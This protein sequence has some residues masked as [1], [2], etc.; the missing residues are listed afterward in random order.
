MGY[1]PERTLGN[2]P[3]WR[4]A[5]VDR[6]ARMVETF[7]NHASVIIWSLGNEAGDGVN[8]EAASA[9]V[10]RHE[11]TRPVHYERADRRTH[12]DIVSH[13]YS[14][15]EEI[16]AEALEPDTR[17]LMLCEYSHGMGNSNGNLF[18]YWDAFKA[19][20]RLQGGAIWDWVDQGLRK[21]LPP[22]FTIKDRSPSAIE[23]RFVGYLDPKDGAEGYIALPDARAL[24]LTQS[25]TVEARLVPVPI[26]R[27]AAYPHVVR[28]Q[29]IVSKG[30]AGYELKQDGEELQFRFMAADSGDA[31]VVRAPVPGDWY[32]KVHRVAGTYDGQAARLLVDGTLVGLVRRPGAMRPGHYPVN[33]RRNPDRL[34]YRSPSRVS[35]VRIY[36][37][38]LWRRL[39]WARTAKDRPR[40]SCCGSTR[41]TSGRPTRAGTARTSPTA[42]IT[43]HRA[44]R[45][46][47]TS[48]RTASSLPI[49]RRTRRW[50]R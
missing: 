23:G 4:D 3:E 8:F 6:V 39:N 28:H 33:I 50:P 36:D 43:G 5:H 20:T 32:G 17:P 1:R 24:D 22:R 27:G 49:A 14:S 34:D 48:T 19:G 25:I 16:A 12:V 38:A 46:T 21:P 13:M 42:A 40:A 47:R 26:V 7:K 35:E 30:E 18:K 2:N 9:W 31:V 29:P 10:H 44:R 41:P 37:R 11:P 45:R 15:P